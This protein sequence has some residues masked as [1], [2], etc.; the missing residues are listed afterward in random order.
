MDI[1]LFFRISF[2]VLW[3]MFGLVRGY[4]GRK[5]ETRNSFIGIKEKLKTELELEGKWFIMVTA[6]F[7]V[8]GAI[9]LILFLLAPSW[10][11]WTRLPLGNWIRR[12]GIAIAI[13]PIF[14]LIWVHR[15]LD[16]QWSLALELQT[17]HKLITFGFSIWVNYRR[18]P[19]EEQ[20]MI[21]EF[22][23]EYREYMKHTGRFLPRSHK[24][25][26]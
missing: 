16:R 18:I 12:L 20:M 11:T 10:W 19:R 25:G 22:G 1:D 8:I 14:F 2:L 13:I 9:G 23:V 4:Y 6:I 17:N 24:K 15:H 7:T 3:I 5:T 21:N 26:D